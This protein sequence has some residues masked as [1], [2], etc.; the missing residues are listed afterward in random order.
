MRLSSLF[1]TSSVFGSH[2]F[3]GLHYFLHQWSSFVTCVVVG[4]SASVSRWIHFA[5]RQNALLKRIL[6]HDRETRKGVRCALGEAGE[7]LRGP[8]SSFGGQVRRFSNSPVVLTIS[9]VK[10]IH[11]G[12]ISFGG[13]PGLRDDDLLA[14]A[15]GNVELMN[16]LARVMYSRW[17]PPLL[18]RL[19]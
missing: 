6:S 3:C 18:S 11:E 12:L 2:V 9:E 5:P 1:Q 17:L 19:P 15:L 8:S 14:S 10:K 16:N 4:R 13:L 7:D